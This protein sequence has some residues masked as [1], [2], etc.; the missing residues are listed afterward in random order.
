MGAPIQISAR[1]GPFG[2]FLDIFFV[3]LG[4]VIFAAA[5]AWRFVGC[6]VCQPEAPQMHILSESDQLCKPK[7]E[8]SLVP[9]VTPCGLA[10]GPSTAMLKRS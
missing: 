2:V 7:R 10:T 3:V 8:S 9:V 1:P 5:L 4:F 6:S